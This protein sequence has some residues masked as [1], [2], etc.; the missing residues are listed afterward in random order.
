MLTMHRVPPCKGADAGEI[1]GHSVPFVDNDNITAQGIYCK[2]RLG[3][4]DWHS[5]ITS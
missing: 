1:R 5:T 3:H 2:Q 4:D